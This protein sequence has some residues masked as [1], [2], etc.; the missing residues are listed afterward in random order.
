MTPNSFHTLTLHFFF[1]IY[2]KE[3]TSALLSPDPLFFFFLMIRRPRSFPLF[4][5][6]P[7][8]RS[9]GPLVLGRGR[10]VDFARHCIA[11]GR[12]LPDRPCYAALEG[13]RVHERPGSI[14]PAA[15]Q[16]RANSTS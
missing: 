13:V 5:S 16:W 3:H 11:A 2:S 1:S 7:L 14:G 4:P 6:T 12:I 10:D 15:M 8:S 9:R